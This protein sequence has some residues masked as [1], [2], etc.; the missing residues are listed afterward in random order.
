MSALLTDEHLRILIAVEDERLIVNKHGRYE[1]EGEER[2]DR[3]SRE[4]LRSRG[5][6]ASRY[7]N[8]DNPWRIT[9]K[10]KTAL[11]RGIQRRVAIRKR[12]SA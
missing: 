1:I 12:A 2:P 4:Q 10:G 11:D 3:K 8:L 5:L 6:I 9:A 7:G